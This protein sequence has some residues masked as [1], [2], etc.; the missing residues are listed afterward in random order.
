MEPAP[1]APPGIELTSSAFEAGGRIPTK[2]TCSGK[3]ISPPLAWADVP[4]GTNSIALLVEDPDAPGGTYTHWTVY[5]I[6]PTVAQVRSRQGTERL[7][8]GR[9][10]VRRRPL[11]RAVPAEGRRGAPLRV[12]PLC[13]AEGP[14]APRWRQ[15]GR[16]PRRDQEAGARPR[17]ADRD[18]QAGLNRLDRRGRSRS[19]PIGLALARR[20]PAPARAARARRR[21]CWS[22]TP[23][24][25]AAVPATP[26]VADQRRRPARRAAR[27]ATSR[28][29]R[30]L[31]RRPAEVGRVDRP[32]RDRGRARRSR[33]RGLVLDSTPVLMARRA[34]RRRARPQDRQVVRV[35]LDEVGVVN[36]AAYGLP[37]G[38][39]SDRAHVPPGQRAARL[40]HPRA[41]G[42]D[43]GRGRPG[44]RQRRVR[45]LRRH[46]P[47]PTAAS[48]SR[49]PILAHAL[50]EADAARPDHHLA[51][52]LQARPVHLRAPRLP[53]R[54][55]RS[56]CMSGA[57]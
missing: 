53:R 41:Q 8:A 17:P 26:L 11:W 20:L 16:R 43:V 31:L 25:P 5:G 48:T 50:H 51:A 21:A 9:E 19:H 23:S 24:S 36:D 28:R 30:A 55:A 3:E 14:E 10:L 35:T 13:A 45:E 54:S 44:R 4:A 32:G 6:P 29:D 15:A 56:T 7:D 33:S 22:T 2:F 18:V 46:A 42:G 49:Q 12:Q 39:I 38:T 40:R 27:R 37:A 47:R 57:P 52:G 34:R 1:D